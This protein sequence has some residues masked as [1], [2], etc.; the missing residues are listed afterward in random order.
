MRVEIHSIEGGVT[1]ESMPDDDVANLVD[2]F[3]RGAESV[4]TVRLDEGASV[5]HVLRANVCR[6]DVV[7]EEEEP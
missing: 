3:R 7:D 5:S 4:L 6:I 2:S 1:I